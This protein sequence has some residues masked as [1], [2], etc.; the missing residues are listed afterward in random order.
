MHAFERLSGLALLEMEF[1]V[2]FLRN[3]GAFVCDE[4]SDQQWVGFN[5]GCCSAV[6]LLHENLRARSLR[7]AAIGTNASFL[8]SFYE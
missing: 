6:G 3:S 1:C 7:A 8:V 5:G 2:Y 4:L